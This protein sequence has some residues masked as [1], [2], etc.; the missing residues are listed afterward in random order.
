MK[1]TSRLNDKIFRAKWLVILIAAVVLVFFGRVV[2]NKSLTQSAL[3]IGLGLE[4]TEEQFE[5]ST[6]SVVVS[7]GSGGEVTRTYAVYTA[8]GATVSEAL[9]TI[10]QK[11]GLL[12]SLSH[13]NVLVLSRSAFS[14]D[15]AALFEPLIATY[16]LPE[17]AVVTASDSPPEEVLSAKMGAAD[18]AANF[19]QASLIQNLG[20]DGLAL[21][22]VKD[23]LAASLSRS[24]SVTVPLIDIEEMPTP[25]EGES[26]GDG[27]Q[28]FSMHRNL[29]VHGGE[30]FV[31][32]EEL[33]QA[34]TLLLQH[35]VRG[36]LSPVL[37]TGEAVEFRVL[38]AKTE[39]AVEGM[40]VRVKLKINLSFLEAQ[41]VETP[42][43][44]TSS[45]EV[46]TKAAKEA[47][48]EIESRLRACHALSLEWNADFLRLQNEVYKKAGYT[49]PEDCLRSID[50]SVEVEAEV[51]EQG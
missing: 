24:A 43:K 36:K 46:V 47:A 22:T 2:V 7:G 4:K 9:D 30:C 44:I 33:A 37:P 50:F 11:M 42:G 51:R 38:S 35:K 12:V 49:M 8:S 1:R 28:E 27:A 48:R 10:A 14:N 29:V 20:G 5:V 6:L 21:V 31:L 16:S 45:D 13:C 18:S 3:V 25:P 32:G 17:Q 23:F 15:H 19:V 26:A 41:N 34:T 40:S 39:Y